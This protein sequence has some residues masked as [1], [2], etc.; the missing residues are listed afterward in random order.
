MRLAAFE[1]PPLSAPTFDGRVHSVFRRVVNLRLGDGELLTLYVGD[2]ASRPPGAITLA[3]PAAFDFS[4]HVGHQSKISC[5]AG[6]LRIEDS[7]VSVDL[8]G[9]RQCDVKTVEPVT[10]ST[11]D[12]FAA[13]WRAAWQTLHSANAAGLIVALHGRRAAGSL[14][15]ALAAR[16]RQS[17]P[18]L[19]EAA[20][21]DDIEAAHG[22]AARL[23]G[24]GPGLTPSGD[25]FLAGFLIGAR[26]TAQQTWQKNFV[27]SLGDHLSTKSS[28]SGDIAL[29]Y[30]THAAA[31]RAARPL[32]KL[33]SAITGGIAEDATK[34]ATVAAMHF[35]H[36][37]GSDTTFG[38]LCG[39]AAW[40]REFAAIIAAALAEDAL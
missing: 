32:I 11:I 10:H 20:R 28:N 15:T 25:D 27:D 26:H 16:A 14:D 12:D 34:A 6:I 31:G 21:T 37:S 38:L 5:R 18:Q 40:Q 29:A 23:A 1:T 24:A 22:A 4:D 35:G 30:L 7:D 8:R 33:A 19:L 9:A 2:D 39:L 36:S 13:S 17:I 3:A